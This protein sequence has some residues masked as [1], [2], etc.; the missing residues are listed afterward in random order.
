MTIPAYWLFMLLASLTGSGIQPPADMPRDLMVTV[1]HLDG[2]DGYACV[3]AAVPGYCAKD[4]IVVSDRIWGSL[5]WAGQNIVA[6]EVGHFL[7]PN[8]GEYGAEAYACRTTKMYVQTYNMTCEGGT[9]KVGI[10]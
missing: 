7:Y 10:R 9:L 3:G 8:D 4:E 6:H 5:L 1:R 2:A